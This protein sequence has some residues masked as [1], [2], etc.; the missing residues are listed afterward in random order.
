MNAVLRIIAL[1]FLFSCKNEKADK[2]NEKIDKIK[3][4]KADFNKD[5]RGTLVS[6]F[7]TASTI[8]IFIFQ[9]AAGTDTCGTAFVN[10]YNSDGISASSNYY[11]CHVAL[12]SSSLC[13][14]IG[15]N[16]LHGGDGYYITYTNDEKFH[17]EPYHWNHIIK[18]TV[19]DGRY[20]IIRQ[21]L[22]LD[23]KQYEIGDSLFGMINFYIVENDKGVKR[24]HRKEA[25]FKTKVERV[26]YAEADGKKFTFVL[27]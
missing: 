11:R 19:L 17:T 20:K 5:L 8:P 15:L 9:N 16:T 23:K 24:E 7:P 6:R 3:W 2:I 27:H 14:D 12:D 4:S 18:D 21:A 22:T 26:T 10:E 13:I 1:V 25:I